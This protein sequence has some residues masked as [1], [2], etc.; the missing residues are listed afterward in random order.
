MKMVLAFI[1]PHRL[2]EV[3]RDLEERVP[4]LPGMTVSDARGF[5]REKV[6]VP[7]H[8]MREAIT[9]FTRTARVEVL[10]HDE[11]VDQVVAAILGGART[12][13]HGDGKLVVLPVE[14]AVRVRTGEAGEEAV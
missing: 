3:T 8:T 5:G 11:Q 13:Q 14:Q 7:P 2:D 4:H 1:Q 10:V 12:G 9:D 6:E